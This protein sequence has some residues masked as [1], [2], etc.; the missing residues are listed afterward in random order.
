MGLDMYLLLDKGKKGS[1]EIESIWQSE[2]FWKNKW[3]NRDKFDGLTLAYWRKAFGIL[4]WFDHNLESVTSQELPD[5]A[6][7]E[8]VQGCQ[9][10][11]VK[12]K[13]LDELLFEC[14]EVLSTKSLE[15]EEQYTPD[16]LMPTGVG[17]FIG[18]YRDINDWWWSDIEDTVEQLRN[19]GNYI[20]WDKDD[21]YFV[22]S[23]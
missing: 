5:D 16:D 17:F 6:D 7:R 18:A 21:A 2:E 10:Y 19:V 11:R 8:G 14:E 13:E 23:Y 9:Y 4:N 12:K 15:Y 20:D 1:Q 3:A 22:I